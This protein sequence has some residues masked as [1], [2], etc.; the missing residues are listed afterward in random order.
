MA[1][2][3]FLLPNELGWDCNDEMRTRIEKFVKSIKDGLPPFV[4]EAAQAELS[5]DL[6]AI[7]KKYQE[8]DDGQHK[9]THVKH[10]D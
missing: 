6:Y 1:G 8:K 2:N 7:I 9:T 5:D 3:E 10:A 4:L